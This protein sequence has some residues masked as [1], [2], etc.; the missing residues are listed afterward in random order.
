MSG[1]VVHV[2]DLGCDAVRPL[3]IYKIIIEPV[4]LFGT[5]IVGVHAAPRRRENDLTR[6]D[7]IHQPGDLFFVQRKN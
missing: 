7:Q 4:E 3:Q 6:L 5:E 1:H 2:R